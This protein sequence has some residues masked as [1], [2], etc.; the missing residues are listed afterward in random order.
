[1]RSRLRAAT[2]TPSRFAILMLV[3]SVAA[4]SLGAFTPAAATADAPARWQPFL[5][6][7]AADARPAAPPGAGSAADSRD[8]DEL[9]AL[10]ATTGSAGRD[11][12][13][14]YWTAK[15]APQ[16]WNEIL[17]TIVRQEKINPVRVS[18]ALALLN[19]AMY[20][21]LIAACDAK[22]VYRQGVPHER[23]GRICSLA[24]PDDISSYASVDAA[25]G[26]AAKLILSAVFPGD[27]ET[28]VASA[29]DEEQVRLWTGMNTRSDLAAGESIGRTIGALAVQRAKTDGADA[30]FAGAIPT[31]PGAWVAAKPFANTLPDEPMAGTWRT[32]L[33]ANGSAVR[34]GPPPAYKSAAWQKEADELVDVNVHLTDAQFQIARFWADGAGT[35]TP[36]G[37]WVRIA[38]DLAGRRGLS[39]ADTARMLAYLSAAQADAAIACWD[40]KYTYWS[41]RPIALIPGFASAII[42]PNFPSYFSGH[43]AFSGAASAVLTALFP[44]DGASLRSMAEEA[45][46][47]RMYGGIHWRSDNEVGLR[48]G[49]QIGGIAIDRMSADGS[50]L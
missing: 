34:P 7:H 10:Q 47:S 3:A 18:R 36:P 24:R 15:S 50:I 25:I 13:I 29:A 1:M 43:S 41:G 8:L 16:R 39:M 46:I 32:W 30:I 20:D 48:V 38:L 4:L 42:T 21:A 26:T 27:T 22:L 37:H 35:D 11:A 19:A 44:A 28:F 31:F 40:A 17:L 45:A 23:D 5:L 2:L 12:T 9:V 49:R 6:A 14:A 33:L